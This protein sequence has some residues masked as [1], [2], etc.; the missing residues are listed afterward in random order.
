MRTAVPE[1][2]RPHV[3]RKPCPTRDSVDPRAGPVNRG[4]RDR[5]DR[6]QRTRVYAEPNKGGTRRSPRLFRGPHGRRTNRTIRRYVG[7]LGATLARVTEKGVAIGIGPLPVGHTLTASWDGRS[8]GCESKRPACVHLLP[9][10]APPTSSPR[11]SSPRADRETLVGKA[12]SLPLE[13]IWTP[14][15]LTTSHRCFGQASTRTGA[16]SHL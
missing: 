14:C 3:V 12:I 11:R 8:D 4:E 10:S 13:F 5:Q 1:E 15:I 16:R 7:S 9:C 6:R 2:R